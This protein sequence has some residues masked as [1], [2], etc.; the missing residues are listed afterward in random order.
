MKATLL[1]FLLL[2]TSLNGSFAQP[3]AIGIFSNVTGDDCE[4]SDQ[5][6]GL[7]PVYI[8]H[9]NTP[10][11]IGAQF[12]VAWQPCMAMTYLSEAVTAPY[13][14]IGTC[15]GPSANGCAIAFGSCVSGPNMILTIQFFASGVTPACCWMHV[16]TD[17]T[18]S[19]PG[20]YIADC[21]DPPNVLI[22]RGGEAVINNDG[23]CP[24]GT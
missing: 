17:P 8:V 7:L 18:A 2:I 5:A 19:P 24:C 23:S 4:L 12:S 9:V 16:A 1:S 11:A 14:K 20:I 10:G 22:A 6:P 13:I 21:E 3:G 15:A